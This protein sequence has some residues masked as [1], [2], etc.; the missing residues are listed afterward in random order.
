MKKNLRGYPLRF[1]YVVYEPPL[2]RGGGPKGRRGCYFS[3]LYRITAI[4]AL[5]KLPLGRKVLSV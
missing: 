4:S 1:S 5:V 2:S 3:T